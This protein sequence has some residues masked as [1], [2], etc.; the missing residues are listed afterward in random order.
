[1]KYAIAVLVCLTISSAVFADAKIVQ[2]I[3]SSGIMGQ[4]PK[5]DT[6]TIYVKG[7]KARID[8]GASG[9]YQI[10]DVTVKKAFIVDPGKKSVMVLTADQMQQTAGMLSQLTGNKQATPP[11]IQKLGTSKTYNGYKCDEYKVSMSNPVPTSGTYCI[12]KELDLQKDLEP[13][14]GFSKEFAQMFGG[15][16]MK[17]IQGYPVHSESTTS[18]MGQT[19]KTSGDLVS[20]SH[21]SQPDTL[22][23]VPA[24]YKVMEMP[25]LKMPNQ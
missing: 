16:I 4:P 1:M 11:S 21:D 7:P 20:V 6:M 23:V 10:I 14:S 18:I 25:S 13:L 24:D 9:P 17:Q 8:M 2:T 5:S 15:D 19:I 12:S 22:F 3:N